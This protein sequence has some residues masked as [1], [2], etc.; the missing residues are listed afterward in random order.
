VEYKKLFSKILAA[1]LGIII[2]GLLVNLIEVAILTTYFILLRP[3]NISDYLWITYSLTGFLIIIFGIYYGLK[4]YKKKNVWYNVFRPNKTNILITVAL[5]LAL[6]LLFSSFY[7]EKAFV[8]VQTLKTMSTLLALPLSF[9]GYAIAFY[10]FSALCNFIYKHKKEDLFKHSKIVIVL[11]LVVL[12]PIFMVLGSGMGA[13]YKQGIMNE[14]CG[15]RIIAYNEPSPAR[16][17][18]VQLNEIIVGANN[19]EIKSVNDLK[20]HMD[21]YDPAIDLTL[22][23]ESNIYSFKPV[24]KEGRHIIGLNLT[25]EMCKR[26]LRE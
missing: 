1:I 13:L 20:K 9:M 11:L 5:S 2:I 10:P 24:F 19:V 26:S 16:E 25:Q 6:V 4:S 21:N 17:N 18:G 12:N 22:K 8:Y 3:E 14:P 7:G 15:V 23:T